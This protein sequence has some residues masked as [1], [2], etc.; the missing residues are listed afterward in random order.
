M[1]QRATRRARGCYPYPHSGLETSRLDS[2]RNVNILYTPIKV[3]LRTRRHTMEIVLIL[4]P[5]VNF[6]PH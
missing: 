6:N 1:L 2:Y 3:F 5:S 4:A